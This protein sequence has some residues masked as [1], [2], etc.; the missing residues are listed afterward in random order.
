MGGGD[1]EEDGEGVD[2]DEIE[3]IKE[4]DNDSEDTGEASGD[5]AV[6][7]RG[8]TEGE[9]VEWVGDTRNL[10]SIDK[11]D[12]ADFFVGVTAPL[13]AGDTGATV[14][15]ERKGEAKE[16][17]AIRALAF[18]DVPFFDRWTVVVPATTG[19]GD[20]PCGIGDCVWLEAAS[21]CRERTFSRLLRSSSISAFASPCWWCFCCSSTRSF[22]TCIM[23]YKGTFVNALVSISNVD[24]LARA[25]ASGMDSKDTRHG[26]IPS[27]IKH[28]F[29][30]AGASRHAKCIRNALNALAGLLSVDGGGRR[31]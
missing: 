21:S 16:G 24:T 20:S 19:E 3:T 10:C 5:A 13:G 14:V 1:G 29:S 6:N 18:F 31:E 30:P 27:G 12:D 26:F 23:R 28:R 7:G 11:D 8:R 4:E 15:N 17:E 9:E 22:R 25:S 2:G